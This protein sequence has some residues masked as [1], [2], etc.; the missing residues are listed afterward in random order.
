MDSM[1]M[2]YPSFSHADMGRTSQLVSKISLT[3]SCRPGARIGLGPGF[4]R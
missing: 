1:R 2:A 4:A 3:V